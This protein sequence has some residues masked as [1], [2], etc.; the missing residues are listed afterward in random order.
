MI[1][2]DLRSD[3]NAKIV[4]PEVRN[5]GRQMLQQAGVGLD[6]ILT[7][8]LRRMPQ[9]EAPVFAWPLV[10]GS[11]VSERTRAL[12]FSGAVLRVEVPDSGWKREMQS[13]ASRYLAAINGYCNEKVERIEF[14]IRQV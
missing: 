7:S 8:S 10:C 11:K 14:V 1:R 6:K 13:L 5:F 4:L 12:D 2:I 9:G 3:D